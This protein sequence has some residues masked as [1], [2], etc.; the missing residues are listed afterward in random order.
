[1]LRNLD[2]SLVGTFVNLAPVIGAVSGVLILDETMG[3][4]AI[5]G[6]VLVFAGVWLSSRASRACP[7]QRG[8]E[9]VRQ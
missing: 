1:M 2:A 3:P 5:V 8:S 4:M 6:G 9:T 7:N